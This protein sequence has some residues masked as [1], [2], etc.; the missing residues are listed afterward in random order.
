MTLENPSVMSTGKSLVLIALPGGAAL[1]VLAILSAYLEPWM[2]LSE[3]TERSGTQQVLRDAGREA[4]ESGDL[5]GAAVIVY[6]HEIIGRG[7]T[8]VQR[9][10]AAGGHAEINAISDALKN[11]GFARFWRLRRDSLSIVTM[12]EPCPM[13]RGAIVQYNIRL[14]RILKE[15]NP[16][17]LMGED[18]ELY[19]YYWDRIFTGPNAMVDSLVEEYRTLKD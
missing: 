7:F 18:L 13:C 10:T 2:P 14:V 4:L 9:D 16:F 1:V 11:V 15:K 8:T 17:T 19:R 6:A 12:L 5:P 3:I